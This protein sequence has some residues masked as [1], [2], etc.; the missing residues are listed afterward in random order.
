[1][2]AG[3]YP[4]AVAAVRAGLALDPEHERMNERLAELLV[5]VDGGLPPS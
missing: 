1:M 3:R 5:R 4:E 2:E